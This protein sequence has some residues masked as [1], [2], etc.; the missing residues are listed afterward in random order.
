[1]TKLQP[2]LDDLQRRVRRLHDGE[3]LAAPQLE[4]GGGGCDRRSEQFD[5]H[6]EPSS[7]RWWSPSASILSKAQSGGAWAGR[8]RCA[9]PR[10]GP[11][12]SEP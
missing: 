10:F 9:Y 7:S 1:M 2:D 11:D 3:S 6:S 8:V 12:D 5:T 4:D